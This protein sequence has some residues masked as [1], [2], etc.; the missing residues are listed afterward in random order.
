MPG[1]DAASRDGPVGRPPHFCVEM[2]LNHLIQGTCST[3][4]ENRTENGVQKEQPWKPCCFTKAETKGCRCCH[5]DQEIYFRFRQR[6]VIDQ[7]AGRQRVATLD[8]SHFQSGKTGF[9]RHLRAPPCDANLPGVLP[10]ANSLSHNLYRER[11]RVVSIVA[12]TW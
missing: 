5:C 4:N 8:D 7:D 1:L 3:R 6:P 10:S 2:P 12:Y 9:A 11:G